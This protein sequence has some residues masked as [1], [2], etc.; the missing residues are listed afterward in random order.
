METGRQA[1]T[2]K[3]T[4]RQTRLDTEKCRQIDRLEHSNAYS[5][6]NT[7]THRLAGTQSRVV[8]QTGKNTETTRQSNRLAHRDMYIGRL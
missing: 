4:D 8:Q 7:E 3:H 5:G 1:G 6:Q 2:Q